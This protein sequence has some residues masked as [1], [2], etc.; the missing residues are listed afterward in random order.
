MKSQIVFGRGC[1]NLITESERVPIWIS[2]FGMINH[3]VFI[4]KSAKY[5]YFQ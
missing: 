5:L 2:V 4:Y 3:F 1:Q